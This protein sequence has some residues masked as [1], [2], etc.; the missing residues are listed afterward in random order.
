M[1]L[2]KTNVSGLAKDVE[3]NLIVNNNLTEYE[4]YLQNKHKVKQLKTQQQEIDNLK[5]DVADMKH[6]LQTIFDR[7]TDVKNT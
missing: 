6:M 7:V 5:R 4:L 1:N 3:T 2:Q